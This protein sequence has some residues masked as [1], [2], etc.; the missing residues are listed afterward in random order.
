QAC[1]KTSTPWVDG[2]I[3][4]LMGAVRVFVPPD[5]ACYECTMN[6]RDRELMAAR[7][8]CAMLTREQMLDG[9]TPTTATTSSV[10][11]AMQAQEAVK[12]LHAEQLPS[13]QLAGAG[14]QFVGLTH[15]SYRVS[16]GRREECLSHDTYALERAI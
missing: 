7:R 9:K 2:A 8:T 16:Y 4:G 12:L 13:A 6:D 15:D 14:F 5:S 11:A 10:I 1:W 3:E